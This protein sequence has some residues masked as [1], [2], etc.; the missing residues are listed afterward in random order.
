MDPTDPTFY[1]DMSKLELAQLALDYHATRLEQVSVMLTE[2]S[3]YTI[4]A[5]FAAKKLSLFQITAISV[6]Y[7]V[8]VLITILGYWG[9]SVE[10][11]ALMQART[12]A[13]VFYT[14][15][16]IMTI[17]FLISWL[18]SIAFMIHSRRI[19]VSHEIST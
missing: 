2:M 8:T 6:V 16:L 1:A 17:T 9:L 4:V 7:S 14:N 3:A 13:S 12:G 15:L 10:S 19:G 18:L 5:Y 11:V